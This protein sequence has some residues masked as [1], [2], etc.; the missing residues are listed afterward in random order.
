[1]LLESEGGCSQCFG[2]LIVNGKMSP[3]RNWRPVKRR[4]ISNAG[5]EAFTMR[6][7]RETYLMKRVNFFELTFSVC[8]LFLED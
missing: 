5:E 2:R 3:K 8:L 4:V 6:K 7:H 1:M